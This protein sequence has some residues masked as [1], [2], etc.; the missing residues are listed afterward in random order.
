M[1]MKLVSRAEWKARPPKKRLVKE[2]NTETTGHWEGPLITVFGKPEWDHQSCASLIRGIQNFHM[3][4]RGWDD[5][6]YNFVECPH[7]YTFEGRGLDVISAANGTNVGN[8]NS[9]AVCFL[10]GEGNP[11]KMEEKVGF[12][13][14]V[15]YIAEKTGAPNSA[16]GHRDWKSTACPGNERY[17]WILARMPVD[18]EV[19]WPPAYKP[20]EEDDEMK[21]RLVRAPSG[22]VYAFDG[23]ALRPA[24]NAEYQSV[25]R[26][27]SGQ[28]ENWDNW[29]QAQIDAFPKEPGAPE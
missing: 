20:G 12:K 27:Y 2:L 28:A 17:D 11:F 24:N 25:I 16:R 29:S 10:A 19:P 1:A 7:G 26:W 18:A 6:A 3:D 14:A 23:V 5:I 22:A 4:T 21:P 8:Q 9:H 13:E 15:K